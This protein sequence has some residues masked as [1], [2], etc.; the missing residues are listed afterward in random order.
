MQFRAAHKGFSLIELLVVLMIV[1]VLIALLIPAVQKAREAASRT[2]C[3]N[4]L[5]QIGL[6]VHH[7]HDANGILP[8]NSLTPTNVPPFGVYGPNTK[9]WSWLALLLPVLDQEA[10]YRQG[11]IPGSTLY[12]ARDVVAARVPGFLCPSDSVFNAGPNDLAADLGIWNP[13]FISAGYTNYKGVGGSNWAW[14]ESRWRNI[15]PSGKIDGLAEGDGMFFRA[16]FRVKKT[17][18]SITDGLSNTFMVGEAVPDK[19]RW[20]SWAY[21][22]N[23]CSTCAIAPNAMSEDGQP[24]DPW[25]WQNSYGFYSRHPGGLFFAYADGSVHFVTNDIDLD[26]YRA[27]ATISGGEVATLP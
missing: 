15:G 13:P 4:N 26:V 10:L 2:R 11:N 20:C 24:F 12:D 16:D 3:Q 21:A 19:C 8:Y 9:S 1:G 7:Y 25:D 17:F 18:A 22:N 14:G 6:A 27:L 23:A 5:K